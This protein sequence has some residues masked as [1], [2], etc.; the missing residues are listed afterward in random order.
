MCVRECV[1]VCLEC[2]GVFVMEPAVS[3]TSALHRL[4]FRELWASVGASV[5]NVHVIILIM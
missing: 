5:E 1:C 2:F 4:P 3:L